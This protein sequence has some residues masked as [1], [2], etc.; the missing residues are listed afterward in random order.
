MSTILL[1]HVLA[2]VAY[3]LMLKPPPDLPDEIFNRPKMSATRI[4]VQ[5][6]RFAMVE[7][8]IYVADGPLGL[9]IY[10]ASD[11]ENPRLIGAYHTD[12]AASSVFVTGTNAWLGTAAGAMILD[13]HD[14][15]DPKPVDSVGLQN[16]RN[17]YGR[18][19]RRTKALAKFSLM[20]NSRQVCLAGVTSWSDQR[21][22]TETRSG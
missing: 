12:T 17:T 20:T 11:P 19:S 2:I 1:L 3:D 9:A 21:R 4:N 7:N 13:V 18:A 6:S 22:I 5:L 16:V 8:I 10:E 14:P 15:T